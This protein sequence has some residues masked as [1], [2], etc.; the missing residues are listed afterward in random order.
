[1]QKQGTAMN[2]KRRLAIVGAVGLLS[3]CGC[4]FE[5]AEPTLSATLSPAAGHIPYSAEV[6]AEAPA[7]TFVFTTPEGAVEQ[8]NGRLAV[9]VDRLGWSCTVTWTAG[10]H[11][12]HET[13]TATAT[14][15]LPDI[16]SPQIGGTGGAWKLIPF[17]RTLIDFSRSIYD[18]HLVSISVR[19]DYVDTPYSIFYP[20]YE[21]GVCHAEFRQMIVDEACIVYP[22]Y[23]S[24]D[25]GGPLP[26]SPTGFDIGYPTSHGNPN[27]LRYLYGSAESGLGI[28]AQTGTITAIAENDIGQRVTESFSIPIEAIHFADIDR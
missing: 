1:M 19:G 25:S 10:D 28:P 21:E 2:A 13:V 12:L 14:N 4:L 22:F 18:G 5:P 3:L 20:P 9:E 24:V 26:Y 7:G 17:Q 8:R 27:A 16:H 23:A 15:P 6:I 11:V